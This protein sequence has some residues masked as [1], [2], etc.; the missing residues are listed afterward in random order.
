MGPSAIT[1]VLPV[2]HARQSQGSPF[3]PALASHRFMTLTPLRRSCWASPAPSGCC[4]WTAA[5]L[6]PAPATEP[7][8]SGAPTA[9]SWCRGRRAACG[10]RWPRDWRRIASRRSGEQAGA[11]T[12]TPRDLEPAC[13]ELPLVGSPL[14]APPVAL[15]HSSAPHHIARRMRTLQRALPAMCQLACPYVRPPALF[16]GS[17]TEPPLRTA[18]AWRCRPP[19]ASSRTVRHVPASPSSTPPSSPCPTTRPPSAH[20]PYGLL[21]CGLWRRAGTRCRWGGRTVE[22]SPD[23]AQRAAAVCAPGTSAPGAGADASSTVQCPKSPAALWRQCAATLIFGS[24][25]R[26]RWCGTMQCGLRSSCVSSDL[27]SV[28]CQCCRSSWTR[29]TS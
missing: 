27:H 21:L 10:R 4:T 12:R 15:L 9:T 29:S 18:R 3:H 13:K 6:R 1:S 26:E 19:T 23:R 7:T 14:H 8:P 22:S 16:T 20:R 17:L 25:N 24:A 28:W 11:A 2:V 5:P